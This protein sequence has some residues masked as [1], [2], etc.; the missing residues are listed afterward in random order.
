MEKK[1]I[2]PAQLQNLHD[3]WHFSP[4]VLVGDTLYISGVIAVLPDGSV[5]PNP[6][7]QYVTCFEYIKA[8]LEEAGGTFDNLVDMVSYHTDLQHS[9]SQ[10]VEVRDRYVTEPYPTWTAV[11][12]RE[13]SNRD[14]VVEI[15]GIARL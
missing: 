6:E 5:P 12:V 9:L 8:V 10:F 3:S 11:G 4:G 14:I 13:L 7:D 15:R 1:A 2:I